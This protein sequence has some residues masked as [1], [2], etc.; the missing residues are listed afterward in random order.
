MIDII[1]LEENFEYGTIGVL[2]IG[3]S[4]FCATLEPPELLNKRNVSCIPAKPYLIKPFYSPSFQFNTYKVMNV[5]DRSGILFHPGNT[6]DDTE[7]CII[8]GQYPNKLKGPSRA[9]INSGKTFKA[10]MAIMDNSPEVKLIIKE[11]Y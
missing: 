6:R 3:R 9:L 10:F 4:V 8:L 11:E 5:P 1:R 7:G 2:R